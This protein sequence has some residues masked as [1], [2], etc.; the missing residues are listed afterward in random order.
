MNSEEN[1]LITRSTEILVI[2]ERSCLRDGLARSL[3]QSS[4]R[5][6]DDI[7]VS[8]TATIRSIGDGKF[9]VDPTSS[10][11]I[12][13]CLGSLSEETITG[14]INFISSKFSNA[15]V[16]LMTDNLMYERLD[17]VLSGQVNGI[18]PSSYDVAQLIQCLA[19]VDTGVTFV[20]FEYRQK[21]KP[22]KQQRNLT[23]EFEVPGSGYDYKL[24][25]RQCEVLKYV[26]LGKS[27][28]FIAAELSL[29]ESTVKVHVHEVMKRLGATSRTHASYIISKHPD[30]IG[31]HESRADINA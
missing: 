22:D 1:Q 5:E 15:L 28:K 9:P 31:R 19:L 20:P 12:I 21:T 25:P 29:C 10:N 30:I 14:D 8:E 23:E 11:I 26:S 18:V 6:G 7:H 4:L 27:N 24:T 3:R 17:F 13:Y 16:V 2:D